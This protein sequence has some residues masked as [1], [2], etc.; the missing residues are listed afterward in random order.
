M[1]RLDSS[2][3]EQASVA[4]AVREV[5]VL[6]IGGGRGG[7]AM[8]DVL[9]QYSWVRI[10]GV[11]D[12]RTD[13]PALKLAREY[14]IPTDTDVSVMLGE[15]DG[16]LV[17]DVTGDPAMRETLEAHGRATG[18]E[19]VSGKSARLMFDLARQRIHDSLA[20]LDRD[21]QLAILDHLLEV[22]E[23]LRQRP[24]MRDIVGQS[25]H[26]VADTAGIHRGLA[27][28]WSGDRNE[29]PEIA[30]ATGI[31]DESD[32]K[33]EQLARLGRNLDRSKRMLMLD[34]P[35]HLD[36]SSDEPAF[37]LMLPLWRKH[38]CKHGL[39][40]LM[41]FATPEGGLA[42]AAEAMFQLAASHLN[43][44]LHILDEYESLQQAATL[45]PLTQA[46]N[47][48]FLER[49]L[50]TEVARCKRAGSG[51]L[52]CLFIDMDDFKPVND[53]LGHAVGDAALRQLTD[54][55]RQCIRSY[56][57]LARYGG[58]EFVVLM[59]A[60]PGEDIANACHAAERIIER[61]R[62]SR[63]PDHP[64][65]KLSVSIGMATQSSET[66]DARKLLAL[67]DKALYAAKEA[68]KGRLHHIMDFKIG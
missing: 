64:E 55:V 32:L 61:V 24:A 45:D 28:I 31:K 37:N 63:L 50:E 56:D 11:A 38:G 52:S 62:E 39:A 5:R 30:A 15:F 43:V 34:P 27:V 58:D 13:A 29:A 25:F 21:A 48:R 41:L 53:R 23:R 60:A 18:V 17:V 67:A 26:V 33:L 2:Q 8:L 42:P 59:P 40:G 51:F 66:V 44:A 47:R 1:A 54:I 49:K 46:Y 16:D 7:M 4:A 57:T 65:I 35:L 9:R 36:H 10:E 19:I 20:I 12:V 14:G 3:L 6:I 68:G 22:T